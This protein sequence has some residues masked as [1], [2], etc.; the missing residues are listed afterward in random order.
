MSIESITCKGCNAPMFHAH[1]AARWERG[2]CGPTVAWTRGTA[3][4]ARLGGEYIDEQTALPDCLWHLIGRPLRQ[5][6]ARPGR[7][8][9]GA[10]RPPLSAGGRAAGPRSRLDRWERRG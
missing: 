1:L 3:K 2:D 8:W 5:G 7:L 10:S 6:S 9:R 4:N